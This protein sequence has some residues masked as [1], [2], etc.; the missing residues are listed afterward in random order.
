MTCQ[1]ATKSWSCRIFRRNKPSQG[2]ALDG[3]QFSRLG[4]VCF[5]Q[6]SW[7]SA[8]IKLP[9]TLFSIC[10]SAE[11]ILSPGCTT[12]YQSR[13]WARL[14]DVLS[15][16]SLIRSPFKCASPR[17]TPFLRSLACQS[18]HLAEARAVF[19]KQANSPPRLKDN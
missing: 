5:L 15:P 18:C 3:F 17:C 13:V 1:S 12:T 6:A 11:F 7:W 19:P 8:Q 4:L 9:K 10:V 16:A 14:H 2:L